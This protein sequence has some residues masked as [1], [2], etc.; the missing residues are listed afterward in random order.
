MNLDSY[1]RKLSFYFFIGL[2]A[3]SSLSLAASDQSVSPQKLTLPEAIAF[4]LQHNPDYKIAEQA[5]AVAQAQYLQARSAIYPQLNLTLESKHTENS[6]SGND[7]FSTLDAKQALYTFGKL[8]Y[9]QEYARYTLRSQEMALE[10]TKQL[11]IYQIKTA[12]YS[13]LLQSELTT[14]NQEAVQSAE[15]HYKTAQLLYEKGVNTLFDATR[16]K[17]NLANTRSSLIAA[18]NDLVK[19]QQNLNQ[20]LNLPPNTRIELIGKLE[21]HEYQPKVD[22]LLELAKLSRP[23]L[24]SQMLLY[25]QSE[26]KLKLRS[27]QHLPNLYFGAD[28]T[29]DHADDSDTDHSWSANINLTMPIFDGYNIANQVKEAKADVLQSKLSY[30]KLQLAVQTQVEQAILEIKKQQELINA[31][32]EAVAVSQL[33]LTMA[34]ASF[35]NGLS[36]SLDVADAELVLTTAKTNL[37]QAIYSYLSGLAALENAIGTTQLP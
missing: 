29:L 16:A 12:F 15:D 23:D 20:L 6:S 25:Q 35:K 21:Y 1:R 17:A 5:V 3:V 33:A 22:Q 8:G 18:E 31:A 30:D 27:A 14:V 32:K 37:A 7:S 26:T 24:K 9:A 2:I 36:T 13:V 10:Q 28:Y 19:E 4:G 11:I 34:Q